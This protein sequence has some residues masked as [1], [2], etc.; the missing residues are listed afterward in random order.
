MEPFAV[1]V[2]GWVT[3]KSRCYKGF[4]LGGTFRG[5]LGH[6]PSHGQGQE[7]GEATSDGLALKIHQKYTKCLYFVYKCVCFVY[8]M[9][10][11]LYKTT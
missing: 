2:W 9:I 1:V 3:L 6:F 4:G 8:K 5:H 10:Q 7:L 11:N